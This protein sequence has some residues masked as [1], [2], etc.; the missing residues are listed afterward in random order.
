MADNSNTLSAKL[1]VRDNFTAQLN[2]FVNRLNN[3]ENAFNKFVNKIDQSSQKIE[4]TLDNI[5]RKM[6]QTSN[7]IVSQ[8]DKVANS[9]LKSTTKVEQSQKKVMDDLLA[10]YIKIGGDIQTIFKNVNKEAEQLSRSGLKINVNGGSNKLNNS[11]DNSNNAGISGNSKSES[12][13]TGLIGGNFT[14]M[15]GTLGVIGAGVTGATKILSTLDGWAMQGFNAINTMSTGLLS[16]N[17]IKEGLD[18]ASEFETNRVAMNV[19]MGDDKKGLEY[20][21]QGVTMA[22]TTPYSERDISSL[23]KKMAGTK[24]DWTD[25]QLMTMLD[26]ASLKPEMGVD[27]VGFSIADA[28][29]GRTTSLKTNYMIDNKEV[30]KYLK[31]LNKTDPVDSKKWKNA[32]NSKG[33]VDNKQEYL[34]LMLDYVQK[35]TNYNGLTEKYS[36]TMSGQM[37]RLSGYWDTLKADLLGIDTK[38]GIAKSGVTVFSSIEGAISGLSDWLKKDDTKVLLNDVGES[39]GKAIGSVTDAFKYALEN[40]NWKLVGS[41][42]ENIGKQ[43]E[44]FIERITKDGTLN[45]LLDNLPALTEMALNNKFIK[46]KTELNTD[47]ALSERNYS[48][49]ANEKLN[50]F[51]EQTANNLGIS[52]GWKWFSNKLQN[53]IQSGTSY[54]NGVMLTDTNASSVLSKSD[55]NEEQ[56]NTIQSMIQSDNVTNYHVTIQSINANNFDEIVESLQK[57]RNDKK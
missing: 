8:T 51:Y 19:L 20:Y 57:Y 53:G 33:A 35:D 25:K 55:L 31:T 39:L 49:A 45:K 52:D 40:V 34:D 5:N 6:E 43:V 16:V 37:T 22:Q 50:G 54:E 48:K 12:F 9:I 46:E 14:R 44:D 32:F 28:M 36:H 23:Q 26:L 3:T 18:T 41:T 56:K 21:Q 42:F 24:V 4:K 17:G 2:K 13:L 29:F 15:L 47:V 10:K 27:H 30:Q 7:K 11:S 38:T 1:E